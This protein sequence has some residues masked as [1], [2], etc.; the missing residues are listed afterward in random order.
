MV[1]CP[2]RAACGVACLCGCPA[3]REVRGAG[4]GLGRQAGIGGRRGAGTG[5]AGSAVGGV[6]RGP[7][8]GGHETAVAWVADGAGKKLKK[9]RAFHFRACYVRRAWTNRCAIVDARSAREDVASFGDRSRRTPAGQSSA[10][11]EAGVR[12]LGLASCQRCVARHGLP[13]ADAGA[14]SRRAH[15]A[16]GPQEGARRTPWRSDASRP[17]MIL[18]DRQPDRRAVERTDAAVHSARFAARE[19]EPVCSTG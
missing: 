16:A 14:A 1:A 2:G 6:E 5:C 12:G 19:Q 15:R 3:R 17:P 9:R 11:V 4:R 10:A 18:L 7:E 13:R 8:P